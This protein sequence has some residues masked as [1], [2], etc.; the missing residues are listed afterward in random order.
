MEKDTEPGREGCL[1]ERFGKKEAGYVEKNQSSLCIH[2]GVQDDRDP[3]NLERRQVTEGLNL[4]LEIEWLGSKD[5][6]AS[7]YRQEGRNKL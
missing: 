2:Q 4:L 1:W 5:T 6:R 7:M 3:F